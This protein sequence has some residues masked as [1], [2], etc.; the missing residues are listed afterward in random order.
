MPFD[1]LSCLAGAS[2]CH[3]ANARDCQNQHQPEDTAKRCASPAATDPCASVQ[4]A[5]E[6]VLPCLVSCI[7]ASAC[8]VFK[9]CLFSHYA[10]CA[11]TD[12]AP[13]GKQK[14][15]GAEW[16]AENAAFAKPVKAMEQNRCQPLQ[17]CSSPAQT[18]CRIVL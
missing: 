16:T 17:P 2:S 15:T 9:S 13:C 1:V 12:T 6:S 5:A 7:T 18:A 4:V 14:M 8:A 3:S 10:S 11:M